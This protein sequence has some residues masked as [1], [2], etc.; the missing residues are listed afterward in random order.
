MNER[1]DGHVF[2]SVPNSLTSARSPVGRV[3][4]PLLGLFVVAL[5]AAGC[6]AAA[7]THRSGT[8]PVVREGSTAMGEVLVAP[9]GSTLYAFSADSPSN[10][11]CLGSCLTTWPPL[12]VAA[13][14]NL[15]AGKGVTGT[16]GTVTRSNG[17]HQVT[18][19]GLLLYTYAG[20]SSPGQ[21][22]GQGIVEQYGPA[23]GTWFAVTPTTVGTTSAP[24]ADSDA[25]A[26][27]SSSKPQPSTTPTSEG[28]SSG[29]WS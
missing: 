24:T 5:G 4:L 2:P 16:L 18:Y 11:V 13:S 8:A 17:T 23:R 29:K 26:G 10:I 28:N 12:A 1:R 6:S 19:N 25:S 3:R 27:T 21:T 9:S 7:A 20:D 14:T 15:T 22:E